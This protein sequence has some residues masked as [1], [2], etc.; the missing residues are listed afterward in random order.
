MDRARR[1]LRDYGQ[2]GEVVGFQ[3]ERGLSYLKKIRRV[4]DDI[5]WYEHQQRRPML[6]AVVM[7]DGTK[8]TVPRPG[9]EKP[10]HGGDGLPRPLQHPIFRAC[11]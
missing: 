9:S 2:I 3:R 7:N 4:L 11:S 1:T 6:S 5:N 10:T 8:R